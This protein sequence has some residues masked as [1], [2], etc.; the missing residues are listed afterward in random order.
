MFR[1][2]ITL[3]IVNVVFVN[4]I[5]G[6]PALNKPYVQ[7]PVQSCWNDY[8]NNNGA[9]LDAQRYLK[10]NMQHPRDVPSVARV[11]QESTNK[12]EPLSSFQAS[13]MSDIYQGVFGALMM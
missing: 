6:S 5:N 12:V 1:L 4:S 3:R 8:V 13:K 10:R 2:V 11:V 7:R 9:H